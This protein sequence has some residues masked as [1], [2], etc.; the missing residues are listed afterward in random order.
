MTTHPAPARA[1]VAN[2]VRQLGPTARFAV[3]FGYERFLRP[4]RKAPGVYVAR[5]GVYPLFYQAEHLPNRESR[6]EPSG[7]RDA[8]GMPRLRTALRFAA[9]DFEGVLRVHDRLDR[10]LRRHGLGRLEYACPEHPAAAIR[11]RML[12]GYAQGGTTRMS[13]R[14]EDGVLDR[15]L[16]VHGFHDLYVASS[17]AFPTS[18]QANTTFMILVLALRLADHLR[19]ALT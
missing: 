19:A 14:P 6:V 7:A 9:A 17:S 13:A 5:P 15:N 2:V 3:A 16:A 4:G 8:L 11:A 12:G 18:S 10:Y 1:H